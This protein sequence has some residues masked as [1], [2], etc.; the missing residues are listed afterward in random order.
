MARGRLGGARSGSGG[1]W[2]GGG[3]ATGR[4]LKCDRV[5]CGRETHL[6]EGRKKTVDAR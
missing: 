5:T 6:Q 3:R 1:R 2:R 4:E